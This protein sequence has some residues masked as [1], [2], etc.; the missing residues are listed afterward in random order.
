MYVRHRMKTMF[1][2]LS[3]SGSASVA[4]LVPRMAFEFF[5]AIA[6]RTGNDEIIGPAWLAITT[7]TGE[8][9]LVHLQGDGGYYKVRFGM[10]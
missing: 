1:A 8:L 10:S 2:A 9:P 5:K 6:Q 3:A 4:S 7:N